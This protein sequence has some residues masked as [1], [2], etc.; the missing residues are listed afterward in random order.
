M[1]MSKRQAF[2][3]TPVG[4]RFLSL[5][6]AGVELGLFALAL[7]MSVPMPA[8]DYE[9]NE[10]SIVGVFVFGLYCVAGWI[11]AGKGWRRGVMWACKGVV[12]LGFVVA[13]GV[14]V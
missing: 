2:E 10:V 13:L 4:R 11:R 3:Q 9:G 7:L 5:L 6:G 1:Y 8:S 12:F 14:T